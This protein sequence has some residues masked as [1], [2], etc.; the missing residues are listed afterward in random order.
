M[1]FK[2]I[3][4]LGIILNW[5]CILKTKYMSFFVF[6]SPP[7]WTGLYDIYVYIYKYIY[8]IYIIRHSCVVS[9]SVAGQSTEAATSDNIALNVLFKV[10]SLKY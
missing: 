1:E 10:S 6:A 2:E 9:M 7:F 5:I 3:F 4:Y 8:K